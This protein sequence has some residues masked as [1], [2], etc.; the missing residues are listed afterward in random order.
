MTENDA[1]DKAQD[2][3]F[4]DLGKMMTGLWGPLLNQWS[5]LFKASE[6]QESEKLK[7]RVGESIQTVAKM[8]QT[9]LSALS[10]PAALEHFQKATQMTPDLAL[11]FAQTC[12]QSFTGLQTQVGEWIQK[13]GAA[14]STADMQ[15]LDKELIRKWADAYEKEFSQYLKLPQIGLG[16][17]YQERALQA[18]DKMNCLQATLSEFLHLLTQPVEKSL[19]SL[20]EKMAEMTQA[21]PLDEKSK[22][23]YNLWIK[24]LEGHYMELFKDPEYSSTLV[25]TLQALNEY[26][27]SRHA[28]VNDVLKQ[29][30]IPTHQDLD[31][32]YKEIYLLKKRMRAYEKKSL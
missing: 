29:L 14:L 5:G 22:T 24:M 9:M 31:E 32:L 12:L 11:G 13:R 10:E 16:R 20:Q 15:E 3:S 6:T 1:A 28:V 17:F 19:K 21:G 4:E 18:V 8:W 30:N 23:Y 25:R 26:V 27:E 7:G 2:K